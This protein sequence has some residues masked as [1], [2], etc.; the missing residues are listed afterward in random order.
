[1]P[2]AAAQPED[3]RPPDL[4]E[5]LFDLSFEIMMADD[6]GEACN[7]ALE[8]MKNLVPAE[9]GAVLYGDINAVGL[10]FMSAFG[11]ASGSLQGKTISFETG[12][13]GFCHQHGVGLIIHDTVTDERHDKSVDQ[14]V[15]FQTRSILAVAILSPGGHTF[16]CLELLNSP[17][18]FRDWHLEAAQTIAGSLGDFVWR[19]E[20]N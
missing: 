2:P 6:I 11:P 10:T 5:D 17:T 16:G 9:A 12:L 4:A 3:D 14:A 8:T 7:I 15:G 20:S 13:A 18:S 19:R 1:M